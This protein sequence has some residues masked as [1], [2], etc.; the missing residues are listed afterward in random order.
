MT[1]EQQEA[2]LRLA[3]RFLDPEDLGL[4]CDAFTR[5][6]ARIVVGIPPCECVAKD[7]REK[8]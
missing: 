2:A 4:A 1:K 5:D 6:L 8:Q 3:N 7:P